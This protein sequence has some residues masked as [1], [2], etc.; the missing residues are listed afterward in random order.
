MAAT[1]TIEGLDPSHIGCS[2]GLLVEACAELHRLQAIVIEAVGVFDAQGL[3]ALDNATSMTGWLKAFAGVSGATGAAWTVLARRLRDL[4]VTA[5]AVRDGR[6]TFDQT[7]A[8][9]ARLDADLLPAFLEDEETLVPILADL[10][11]ADIGRAMSEWCARVRAV[12][13]DNPPAD[14]RRG[15]FLSPLGDEWVLDATLTPE[16]GEL[17]TR[18]I[19]EATS[20]D[21]DGEPVRTASQKRADALV[22]VCRWFLD[23]QKNPP[24]TRRRPHVDLAAGVDDVAHDGPART[25]TGMILDPATLAR[26]ACDAIISPLLVSGRAHV[27]HYGMSKRTVSTALFLALVARD[28]HCRWPGCDRTPDWCDA[29]HLTHWVKGGPT[30]IDN[31]AL[32]CTR[33]HHVLH[34][35][36]WHLKLDPSDATLHITTPDGRTLQSRPPPLTSPTRLFD[37]G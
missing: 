25:S 22:D 31:L 26:L 2:P 14:E 16:G 34:K 19:A 12:L 29:H 9:T 27:L 6:L 23:H 8:L 30:D 21:G 28:R 10:S 17:V 5:A 3:W 33:H 35:P 18:A 15:L 11:V 36:G 1:D 24:T 20:R 32:F 37:T 4:P 7:R 13:D